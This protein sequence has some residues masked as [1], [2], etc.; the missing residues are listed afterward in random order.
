MLMPRR[1]TQ[2][3]ADAPRPRYKAPTEV[4][5]LSLRELLRERRTI[6][7]VHQNRLALGLTASGPSLWCAGDVS[8]IQSCVVAIVGTRD[9]SSAGAARARKLGRQL[10]QHG[11]VVM[12]GLARGV[13]TEALTSAIEHNGRVIAVVGTPID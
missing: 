7:E 13:D 3:N 5:V 8:L 2:S 1:S 11:V 6:E 12:S 10:A 9:V 4:Q